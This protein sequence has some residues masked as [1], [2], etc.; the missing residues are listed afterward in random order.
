MLSYTNYLN[1]MGIEDSPEA[2]KSYQAFKKDMEKE[3]L[4]EGLEELAYG[5]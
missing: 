1:Y 4:S 5:Y 3:L 2:Q